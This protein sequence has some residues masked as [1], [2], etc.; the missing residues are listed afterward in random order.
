MNGDQ[1][2]IRVIIR[3]ITNEWGPHSNK[4]DHRDENE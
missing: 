4:N 3:T 2:R 1:I